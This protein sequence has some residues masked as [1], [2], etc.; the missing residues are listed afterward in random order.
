MPYR[1]HVITYSRLLISCF[2]PCSSFVGWFVKW[3]IVFLVGWFVE[4]LIVFLVGWFVGW[5]IGQHV[6]RI[7]QKLLNRFPQNLMITFGVDQNEGVE[8]NCL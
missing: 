1:E 3:L 5:L 7:T 4:W 8:L 2:H 6:S